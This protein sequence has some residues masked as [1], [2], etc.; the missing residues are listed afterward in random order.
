VEPCQPGCHLGKRESEPHRGDLYGSVFA[1]AQPVARARWRRCFALNLALRLLARIDLLD[2]A[3]FFTW[4]SILSH[5]VVWS[6][7]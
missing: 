2:L 1:P 4:G 3:V 5:F 7:G 6:V